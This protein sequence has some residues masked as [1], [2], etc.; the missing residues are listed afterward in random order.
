MPETLSKPEQPT[1]VEDITD[2]LKLST[3][4]NFRCHGGL[5]WKSYSKDGTYWVH[6]SMKRSDPRECLYRLMKSGRFVAA[7][8]LPVVVFAIENDLSSNQ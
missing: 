4:L 6:V 7:G 8:R 5:N 1:N 3:G 2:F